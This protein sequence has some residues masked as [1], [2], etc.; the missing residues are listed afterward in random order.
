MGG[1]EHRCCFDGGRETE[2]AADGEGSVGIKLRVV[3]SVQWSYGHGGGEKMLR[4]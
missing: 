4:W 1:W 3:V 2:D